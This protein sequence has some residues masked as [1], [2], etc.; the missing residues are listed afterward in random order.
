[1][2]LIQKKPQPDSPRFKTL[3]TK[4][5]DEL[6]S[7]T[8]KGP[9]IIEEEQRTGSIDVTVIWDRWK[10]LPTEERGRIIV[11]AYRRRRRELLAKITMVLGLTKAEA[12]K[13][14]LGA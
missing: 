10:D 3:V 2:P 4:L 7:E 14:G 11:D 5:A 13:L 1:M 12:T 8:P 9:V 6:T